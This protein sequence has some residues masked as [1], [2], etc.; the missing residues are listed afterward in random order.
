MVDIK[1]FMANETA[2][3]N[4]SKIEA[5]FDQDKEAS[6]LLDA[7]KSLQD[8]YHLV[9]RYVVVKFEDFSALFSDVLSYLKED[10]AVLPD[11]TLDCVVGGSF[12]D[13]IWNSVK[14]K[15]TSIILGA[16]IGGA[17]GA[18]AGACVAGGVGAIV[19]G[20]VGAVVGAIVGG[21]AG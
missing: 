7:A 21:V 12:F 2:A 3:A 20:A 15:V 10:K 5:A 1:A 18:V 6:A 16:V 4:V 9:K 11:E 13:K 17:V 19:G 14:T 8:V